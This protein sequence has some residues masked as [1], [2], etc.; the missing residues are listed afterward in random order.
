MWLDAV[1]ILKKNNPTNPY[2]HDASRCHASWRTSQ[3]IGAT[4][5]GSRM[6]A[7]RT[8]RNPGRTHR[9]SGTACRSTRI[10]QMRP[11]PLGWWRA[12]IRWK[13]RHTYPP[14]CSV[15]P[16]KYPFHLVVLVFSPLVIHGASKSTRSCL[17]KTIPSVLLHHPW[18]KQARS[19]SHFNEPKGCSTEWH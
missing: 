9:G 6:G 10:S 12:P 4:C 3:C 14:G 5:P 18:L 8:S 11:L 1:G 16:W 15:M 13:E 7:C 2:A 17:A 19:G